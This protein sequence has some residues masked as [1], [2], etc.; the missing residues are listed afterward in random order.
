MAMGAGEGEA[1]RC[2]SLAIEQPQTRLDD[3]CVGVAEPMSTHCL[4]CT[5]AQW[6]HGTYCLFGG[7]ATVAHVP[8]PGKHIPTGDKT[9]VDVDGN[10]K[11]P[12][13]SR[14]PAGL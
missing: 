13:Q 4:H 1:Q 7:V 9:S 12:G 5:A 3:G 8:V 11:L 10:I 14:I 6:Q 2:M